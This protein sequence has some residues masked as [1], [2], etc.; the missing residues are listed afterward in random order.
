MRSREYIAHVTLIP[1]MQP[2]TNIGVASQDL[3][4]LAEAIAAYEQAIT[5]A[6]RFAD[7][8]YNLAALYEEQEDA[9]AVQQLK[10]YKDLMITPTIGI[11][12]ITKNHTTNI[13]FDISSW[14]RTMSPDR[15][16]DPGT[17]EGQREEVGPR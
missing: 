12:R 16:G 14:R 5:L 6:P 9:L 2:R 4:D 8:R 13:S 11:K 17:D 7:A 15:E 10:Q 1:P 3:G